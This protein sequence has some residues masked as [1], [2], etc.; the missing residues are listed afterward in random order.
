MGR[1][2]GFENI[3]IGILS[4]DHCD[5]GNAD[6]DA[7]IMKTRFRWCSLLCWGAPSILTIATATIEFMPTRLLFEGT[8]VPGLGLDKCFFASYSAQVI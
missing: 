5:V 8:L 2:Q 4:H 3:M 6:I 1:E 7:R